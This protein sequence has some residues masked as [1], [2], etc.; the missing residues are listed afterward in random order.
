MLTA[1][2]KI[3]LDLDEVER[4]LNLKRGWS[5]K[6]FWIFFQSKLFY[7]ERM[8]SIQKSR[9]LKIHYDFCNVFLFL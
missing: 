7:L 5:V 9:K 2:A 3:E 8:N 6:L 4:R 1:H